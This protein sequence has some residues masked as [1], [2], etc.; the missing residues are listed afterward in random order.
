VADP[1]REWCVR[2][3]ISLVVIY[4]K[5]RHRTIYLLYGK[6]QH[7]EKKI[8]SNRGHLPPPSLWIR[9][10]S[11]SLS[12]RPRWRSHLRIITWAPVCQAAQKELWHSKKIFAALRLQSERGTSSADDHAISPAFDVASRTGISFHDRYSFSTQSGRDAAARR[13]TPILQPFHAIY[14]RYELS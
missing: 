3:C 6:E 10:C 13:R 1:A 4:R 2:Q 12:D 14:T 8:L 11:Y 7:I 5:R 9:H